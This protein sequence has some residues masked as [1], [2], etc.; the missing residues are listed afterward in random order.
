MWL[1][2][3]DVEKGGSF[4]DLE[5]KLF[6]GAAG[7]ETAGGVVMAEY[8]GDGILLEGFAEND[9]GVGYGAGDAAFADHFQLLDF[10]GPVEVEYGK[11][12]V[13]QVAETGPQNY[14]QYPGCYGPARGAGERGLLTP[15]PIPMPRQW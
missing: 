11:H 10:I 15:G 2:D 6:V 1:E 9:A 4:F 13:P 3:G 5:G 7:S 12:F 14:R 8:E